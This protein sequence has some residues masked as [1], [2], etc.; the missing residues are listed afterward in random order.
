M[1]QSRRGLGTGIGLALVKELVELHHG[2][3]SAKS[4]NGLTSFTVN[5]PFIEDDSNI[6]ADFDKMKSLYMIT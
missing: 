6:E 4:I 1:A 5:L 3:V 2:K